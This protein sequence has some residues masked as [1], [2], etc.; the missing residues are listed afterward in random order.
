ME[1][2]STLNKKVILNR[3][4]GQTTSPMKKD[5][6]S[7]PDLEGLINEKLHIM[8]NGHT[9]EEKKKARKEVLRL[10]KMLKDID[11]KSV[12]GKH[13]PERIKGLPDDK[14]MNKKELF[15]LIDSVPDQPDRNNYD[16]LP[17]PLDLSGG[18]PEP[19]K[20]RFEFTEKG[21]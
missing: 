18:S 2:N 9:I 10:E 14:P 16:Y 15:K 7:I 1:R 21:W 4:K 13:Y 6:H 17:Y 19:G 12:N 11:Y 8:Q 3:P 5:T 20:N